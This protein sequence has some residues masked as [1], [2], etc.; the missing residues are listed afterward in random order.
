MLGKAKLIGRIGNKES[1]VL[2]N[3]G[4]ITTLSIATNKKYNDSQGNKKEVTTW[5]NVNFFGKLSEIANKYAQVG[6][7]VYIEGDIENKKIESGD[8]A[9]QYAYSIH[10]NEIKLLTSGKKESGEEKPKPKKTQS[11]VPFDD[12][13]IPAF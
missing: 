6:A 11:Y 4:E 7:L 1:K 13:D 8:R 2:K 12:D 9:G 3:G 10:A 5:H